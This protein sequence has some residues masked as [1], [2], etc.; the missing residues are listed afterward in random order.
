MKIFISIILLSLFVFPVVSAAIN[1]GSIPT[2]DE[3]KIPNSPIS[4]PAGLLNTLTDV[5]GWIYKIFFIVAVIFIIFAAFNFLFN[6]SAP[7]K[8]QIAH[9]QLIYAA[10]AIVVALLAVSFNTII[11]D[12]LGGN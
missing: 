8:I 6:S 1:P 7:D 11:I 4:T 3:L 10:V 5:A 9:T 12:F 2:S